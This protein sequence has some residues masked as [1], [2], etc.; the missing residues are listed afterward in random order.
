MKPEIRSTYIGIDLRSGVKLNFLL[1]IKIPNVKWR[2]MIIA[3]IE[4]AIEK[5]LSPY[6]N[7]Q[8]G[9]PKLPVLG[10]ISGLSSVTGSFFNTFRTIIPKIEKHP[11]K[12]KVKIPN[13]T[14]VE[15]L[16]VLD[17]ASE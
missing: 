2:S 13:L 1:A 16:S 15:K 9:S 6:A 5:P 4:L 11:T 3:A 8:M 7:K 12:I 10:S 17:A 14:N